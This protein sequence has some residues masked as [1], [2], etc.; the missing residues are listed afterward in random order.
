[1]FKA[2]YM[3]IQAPGCD[4]CLHNHPVATFVRFCESQALIKKYGFVLHVTNAFVL[5]IR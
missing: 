1:M 5:G 2:V 3:Q 4:H